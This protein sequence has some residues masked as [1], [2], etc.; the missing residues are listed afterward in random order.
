MDVDG[1]VKIKTAIDAPMERVD[2]VVRVFGAEAAEQDATMTKNTV[3]IRLSEVEQF[4]A[5]A[6][7]ATAK[8]V[9][10]DARGYEQLVRNDA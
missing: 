5:G 3:G 1:L 2:D 4:G 6:D 7:V 10:G 8:V 9:R